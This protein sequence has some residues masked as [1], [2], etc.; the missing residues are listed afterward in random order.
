MCGLWLVGFIVGGFGCLVCYVL[1][2][3]WFVVWLWVCDERRVWTRVRVQ[4][5][6]R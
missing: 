6:R 5:L 1:V 3:D 4:V 2:G